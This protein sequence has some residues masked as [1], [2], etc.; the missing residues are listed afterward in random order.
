M[1]QQLSAVLEAGKLSQLDAL[2]LRGRLQ[3]AA[4]NLFGRIAKAA[5]AVGT[6]HAYHARS[7]VDEKSTLSLQLYKKLLTISK[8]REL[9]AATG[10]CWYIHRCFL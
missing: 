6:L 2:R 9:K 3:F 1:I 8:P 10:V 7:T 5:L 4:G